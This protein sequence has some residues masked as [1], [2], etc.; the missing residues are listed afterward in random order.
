MCVYSKA[1]C[2]LKLFSLT[3]TFA[4]QHLVFN[5]CF[6]I[7]L[8]RDLFHK[9]CY[10]L[11]LELYNLVPFYMLGLATQ[12]VF[13]QSDSFQHQPICCCHVVWTARSR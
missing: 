8:V 4:R 9:L 7:F 6:L 1:L 10:K 11:A 13:H 5:H 2:E 3:Y 12:R